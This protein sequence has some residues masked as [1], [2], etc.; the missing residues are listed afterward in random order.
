MSVAPFSS[1]KWFLDPIETWQSA[2]F[3]KEIKNNIINQLLIYKTQLVYDSL[4]TL[5]LSTHSQQKISYI[6]QISL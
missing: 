4:S 3:K 2:K 5:S 6:M 1:M